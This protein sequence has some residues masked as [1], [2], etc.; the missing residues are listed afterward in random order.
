M[1]VAPAAKTNELI[2]RLE[3]LSAAAILNQFE[4][5]RISRET[6]DL[7]RAD[8]GGAHSVLGVVAALRGDVDACNQ[9]HETALRLD[10]DCMHRFNYSISLSHLEENVR[11]LEVTCDALDAFP[12]NLQL[13]DRAITAAL[14]SGYF[15]KAR[16]LC[17]A[18]EVVA[19]KKTNRLVSGAKQLAAATDAQLFSEQ[20]VRQVLRILSDVQRAERHRKSNL[21]ITSNPSDGNFLYNRFLRA[22]PA[23]A[24][25]LNER[26]ADRIADQPVLLSDPGLR[27]VA[28]FTGVDSPDGR[29]A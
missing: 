13:I 29:I 26:L 27:F 2:K 16:E 8:P 6:K 11:S 10:R 3:V 14:D 7:M 20:G 17:D 23:A 12:D 1:P 4:L 28:L 5:E 25:G 24:S 22:T 15:R 18:R 19:P 9:H 21:V